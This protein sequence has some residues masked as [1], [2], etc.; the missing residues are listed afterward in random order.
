M[1]SIL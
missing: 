1:G